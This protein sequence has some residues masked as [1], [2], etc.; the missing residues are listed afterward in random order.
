[1]GHFGKIDFFWKYEIADYSARFHEEFMLKK[2]IFFVNFKKQN[3]LRAHEF[4][5]F[6]KKVLCTACH[7]LAISTLISG[8][9]LKIHT[10][11]HSFIKK[12]TNRMNNFFK[13]K[14]TKCCMCSWI[15]LVHLKS[16][17]FHILR[18]FRWPADLFH[19][20]MIITFHKYSVYV[21]VSW[22]SNTY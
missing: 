10:F 4:S 1:M 12:Y 15:F 17:M 9:I 3:V 13:I 7:G 20:Y 5:W 2:S 11:L 16:C 14:G 8:V 19:F 18:S 22:N 6:A 21:I